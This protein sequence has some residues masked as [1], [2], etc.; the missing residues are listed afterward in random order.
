MW[1]CLLPTLLL[2]CRAGPGGLAI[3]RLQACGHCPAL[4]CG[5]SLQGQP[6]P[7]SFHHG[8]GRVIPPCPWSP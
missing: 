2:T 5:S 1:G 6:G 7:E 3:G 8:V 4:L